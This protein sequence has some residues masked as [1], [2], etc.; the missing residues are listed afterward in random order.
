MVKDVYGI[1]PV[2][3]A[4]VTLIDSEGLVHTVTTDEDGYY[5]F[6][7]VAPGTNY[8]INAVGMVN[9]KRIV[10]RDF[11]EEVIAGED[12][13]AGIAEQLSAPEPEPVPVPEPNRVVW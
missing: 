5:I 11:V 8:I 3:N 13:D 12:Y 1:I 6:T 4:I 7:D 10:Y 2:P 9:G